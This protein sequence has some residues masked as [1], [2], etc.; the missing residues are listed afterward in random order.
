MNNGTYYKAECHRTT[1]R[2]PKTNRVLTADTPTA[3]YKEVRVKLMGTF[4]LKEVQRIRNEME[5]VCVDA[6]EGFKRYD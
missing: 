5:I 3:L 1:L 2:D 6:F 4:G